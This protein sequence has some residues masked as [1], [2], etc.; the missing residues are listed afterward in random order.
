M[1]WQL[2]LSVKE[3]FLSIN[4]II[5]LRLLR[6]KTTLKMSATSKCLPFEIQEISVDPDQ[7]ALMEQSDLS[8]HCLL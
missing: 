8:P 7:T 1:S 5:T 6:K 4:D 3:P 2:V